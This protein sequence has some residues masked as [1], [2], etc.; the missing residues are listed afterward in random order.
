MVATRN[1]SKRR[2]AKPSAAVRRLQTR[3]AGPA[4]TVVRERP[5]LLPHERDEA[6]IAEP[7]KLV[8]RNRRLIRQAVRD[9]ER[10]LVDTE[11]RGVPSNVPT[12]RRR[13][14]FVKRGS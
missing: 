14:R 6:A 11:T 8:A 13:S 7:R 4:V 12:A 5:L 2:S 9:V 1:R 10:G 3:S